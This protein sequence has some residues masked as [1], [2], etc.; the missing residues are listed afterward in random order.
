M[1][2]P[3][4]RAA[5]GLLALLACAFAAPAFAADC[6]TVTTPNTLGT[7]AN[8]QFE[9]LQ[10]LCAGITTPGY[11]ASGV[12]P[13]SSTFTATGQSASFTPLAGRPFNVSV[14][15][16]FVATCQLERQINS[17]WQLLTV[18]ASGSVVQLYKWS[19][20]ASEI[21]VE[22]EFGIP[23]RINCTAYTSGTVSYRVS[24]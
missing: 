13:V 6:S 15:G 17:V 21:V 19:T 1:K 8:A 16:T 18:S 12:T 20:P 3:L 9:I 24:Q 2:T 22:P 7:T 14:Q 5:F 11:A 4:T 10:K 23:Y